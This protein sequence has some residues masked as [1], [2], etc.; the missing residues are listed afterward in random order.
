MI[1]RERIKKTI[2]LERGLWYF[3]S[4]HKIRVG[5][6]VEK[7]IIQR[8]QHHIKINSHGMFTY[9]CRN[10]GCVVCGDGNQSLFIQELRTYGCIESCTQRHSQSYHIETLAVSLS[11]WKTK[12]INRNVF[13]M[14]AYTHLL[15]FDRQRGVDS[16]D[17]T[18][19]AMKCPAVFTTHLVIFLYLQ[20]ALYGY[21]HI[22]FTSN[23]K[24]PLRGAPVSADARWSYYHPMELVLQSPGASPMNKH[25][26]NSER[27]EQWLCKNLAFCLVCIY[28][29]ILT[30]DTTITLGWTL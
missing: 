13:P 6:V 30:G 21:S 26:K 24:W 22:S 10:V 5:S 14:V 11:L 27:N 20:A 25:D 16:V 17:T 8:N 2:P 18:H 12:S 23:E 4:I 1:H 9:C 29:V 3:L 7:D 28:V 19:K 15:L